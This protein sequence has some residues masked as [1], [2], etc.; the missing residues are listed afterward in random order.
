MQLGREFSRPDVFDFLDS[1]SVLEFDQWFHYFSERPFTVNLMQHFGG[2]L[3]A[4]M[5]NSSLNFKPIAP[6]E[7]YPNYKKPQQSLDDQATMW[8]L[9]SGA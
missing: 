2:Q 9:M 3:C 1:L 6:Q 4:S 7:F 8:S 5:Y